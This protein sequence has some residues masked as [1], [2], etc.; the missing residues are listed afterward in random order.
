M[1]FFSKIWKVVKKA[2]PAVAGS[3]LL[4]PAGAGLVSAAAGGAIGGGIGG[5]AS[6]GGLK[7]T[8]LGALGGYGIGTGVGSLSN[9]LSGSGLAGTAAQGTAADAAWNS[10]LAGNGSFGAADAIANGGIAGGI[11]NAAPSLYNAAGSVGDFL[12]HPIDGITNLASKGVNSLSNILSGTGSPAAVPGIG[13]GTT[14]AGAGAGAGAGGSSF[15]GLLDLAG[16][17]GNLATQDKSEEQ[18]LEQQRRNMALNKPYLETGA[19][20]NQALQDRMGEFTSKFSPEDLTNDPGYKFQLQQ[21]TQA[22]E[23]ANS[24]AGGIDSGEALKAAQQFG[25]GLADSTYNAAFT[26]WLQNNAQNYD[27]L[28]G[29]Q[30]VGMDA[31]GRAAGYNTNVGN[32]KANATTAKGNTITGTLSS[33]LSGAGARRVIGY[34][35]DGTA[36]YA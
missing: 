24:A 25:T 22:M 17:I 28:A 16:G 27:V 34:K 21:G 12:S 9:I 31:T 1:G 18:L 32:I 7:G 33:I 10:A 8:A 35:S 29:Q 14:V 13:K 30:G 20:A 11:A 26:R 4:G 5:L 19:Q 23:R 2:A 15:G 3:L 36:I 6:G